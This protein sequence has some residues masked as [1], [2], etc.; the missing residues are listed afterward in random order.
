MSRSTV[1]RATGMALRLSSSQTF[2]AAIDVVVVPVD[3]RDLLLKLLIAAIL[4]ARGASPSVVVGRGG[5]RRAVLETAPW[6]STR[7]PIAGH[8]PRDGPCARR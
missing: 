6:K 3:L 7:H 2:P 4:D 5:N 8:R 1:Q